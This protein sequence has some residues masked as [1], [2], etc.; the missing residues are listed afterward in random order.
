MTA[1]KIAFLASVRSVLSKVIIRDI[2]IVLIS[3]KVDAA[4]VEINSLGILNHFAR[5]IKKEDRL[6]TAYNLKHGSCSLKSIPLH[7]MFSL[8]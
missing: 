6:K 3:K 5:I 2:I 4:I 8:L 1:H 7:F